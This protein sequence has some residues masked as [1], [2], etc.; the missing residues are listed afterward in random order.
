MKERG[1]NSSKKGSSLSLS[2]TA[3]Y[4]WVMFLGV[5]AVQVVFL[6]VLFRETIFLFPA[7]MGETKSVGM[8]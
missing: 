8:A 5:I 1:G 6:V 4:W 2:V 3:K 7:I